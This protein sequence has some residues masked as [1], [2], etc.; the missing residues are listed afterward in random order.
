[1]DF[2]GADFF[3]VF[4]E[5]KIDLAKEA[6]IESRTVGREGKRVVAEFDA[7]SC[8]GGRKPTHAQQLR[9][10]AV[11]DDVIL[12]ELVLSENVLQKILNLKI[13]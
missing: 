12:V 8:V 6:Q 7:L 5:T 4:E 3:P 1:M 2:L 13:Y 10:T 9:Q 11:F